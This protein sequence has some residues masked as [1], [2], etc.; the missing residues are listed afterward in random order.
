MSKNILILGAGEL[1]SSILHSLATSPSFNPTSQTLTVL[2]RPSTLTSSPSKTQP[3]AALGINLLAG[4]LIND[5]IPV[6]AEKF[7]PYDTIV[8]CIGFTAGKGTQV[9]IAEAVLQAGVARFIPWQF[10]VDYDGIGR[11]SPQ[12]LFDEQLDVRDMLRGQERVKW[13]VVSTGMF[14]SFVFHEG[15]GVV[16]FKGGVVR[17]LGGWEHR[18]TVMTV[19]DI[20][21]VTGEMVL[22]ELGKGLF[23]ESGPVFVG[24]DTVSYGELAGF[25]ERFTGREFRR[26]VITVEQAIEGARSDEAA[27]VSS[28]FNKYRAVFG[29]GKGVAWDMEGTWNRRVGIPTM[30]LKEWAE[31]N[32]GEYAAVR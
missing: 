13:V 6:L 4:D 20:G 21:R 10:G 2:L 9:K 15:F 32:L 22:G 16:D 28:A 1:G 27:G 7:R 5:S 14:M 11:G 26:E 25:L 3:L 8:S 18:V 30:T 23:E 24:G 12:D 19:E 17:A 31:K 29:Q